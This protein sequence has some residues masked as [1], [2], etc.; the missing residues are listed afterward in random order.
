MF[1]AIAS[2]VAL[3]YDC[4]TLAIASHKEE[5]FPFPDSSRAFLDAFEQVLN[6]G[7]NKQYWHIL[8]P[9]IEEGWYK[10]DVLKHAVK[11]K[12]PVELTLTCYT[13]INGRPCGV[14]RGCY[15]RK[16]AY[17]KAGLT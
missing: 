4:T 12:F 6:V 2:S 17:E 5:L 11:D 14:C 9:F 16:T 10:W 8:T 13:P 15:D 1:L 3:Q 7:T